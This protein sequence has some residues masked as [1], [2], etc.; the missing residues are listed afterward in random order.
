MPAL[1]RAG[2]EGP[3]QVHAIVPDGIALA[4]AK[5]GGVQHRDQDDPAAPFRLFELGCE[6]LQRN[7]SLVLIA[8]RGAERN[9]ALARPR[10]RPDQ[11]RHR[12]QVVA[13]D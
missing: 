4:G 12:D 10:L 5:C 2:H 9:Q 7:R 13:P 1:P 6:V 3:V 8:M 11:H